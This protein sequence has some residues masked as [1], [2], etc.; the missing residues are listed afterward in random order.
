M[1]ERRLET[2]QELISVPTNEFGN[3]S[4]HALSEESDLKRDLTRK[5]S[6]ESEG[7]INHLYS[8]STWC[9]GALA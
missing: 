8:R 5:H 1:V 6:G 4:T 9:I 7:K 3:E 2:V